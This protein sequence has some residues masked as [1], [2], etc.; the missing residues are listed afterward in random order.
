MIQFVAHPK[1]L[2]KISSN[3]PK[4]RKSQRVKISREEDSRVAQFATYRPIWQ[5]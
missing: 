1:F 2:V 3:S 4:V 5:P